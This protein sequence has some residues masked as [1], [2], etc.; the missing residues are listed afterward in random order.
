[1]KIPDEYI[2][3]FQKIY[4]KEFGEKIT[5]KEAYDKFLRLVNFMRVILYPIPDKEDEKYP[6]SSSFDE[7]SENDKLGN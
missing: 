3:E 1:M 6:D 7:Q 2:E 5:R 4:L